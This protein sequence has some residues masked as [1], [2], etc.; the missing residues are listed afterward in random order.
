MAL[1]SIRRPTVVV[2]SVVAALVV[3]VAVVAAA[4]A[5]DVAVAFVSVVSVAVGILAVNVGTVSKR[6]RSRRTIP[7]TAYRDR[8]PIVAA[9]R[10]RR[11]CRPLDA[12]VPG[13][14]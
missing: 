8:R 7:A 5:G 9:F 3:I 4:A 13:H 10:R 14:R 1:T 2:A 12:C 6:R 11:R